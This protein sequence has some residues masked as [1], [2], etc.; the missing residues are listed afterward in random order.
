[1]PSPPSPT[2]SPQ[3]RSCTAPCRP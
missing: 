3:P 2:S 1:C